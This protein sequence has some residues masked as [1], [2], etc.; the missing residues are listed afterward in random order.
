ME[1][2]CIG[3]DGEQN[4]DQGFSNTLEDG[5]QNLR[6]SLLRHRVRSR[7]PGVSDSVGLGRGLA[8]EFL[9]TSQGMAP[10]AHFD[11]VKPLWRPL[12]IKIGWTM[13]PLF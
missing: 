2:I 13:S 7:P 6:E 4:L 3:G 11:K 12:P 5:H 10:T 9:T 8:F 1:E